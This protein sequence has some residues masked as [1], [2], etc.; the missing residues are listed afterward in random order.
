VFFRLAGG[1]EL[2]VG[3]CLIFNVFPREIIVIA[4]LPINLT[5]TVFD[6]VELVGHL[7]IYGA[8]A[9][10]L[11]WDRTSLPLWLRGLREGPLPIKDSPSSSSERTVPRD[12]ETVT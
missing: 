1:V 5:L 2:L 9:A 11:I 12:A 6:W 10:L 8:F 7:P 3:A 4:W